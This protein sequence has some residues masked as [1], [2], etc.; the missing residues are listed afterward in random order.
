[1]LTNQK[2]KKIL[3]VATIP[4][5]LRGFLLPF[6]RHFRE[7]GWCVDG[8]ACGISDSV[9]CVQGFDRVWDVKWSRNPLDPRNLMVTPQIIQKIVQQEKY[10]IVHVHTPVAAFVTRYALKDL[11][12]QLNTQVIYT[13]HGFHF[14][15]G[16][17]PLKNAVFLGIEKF[18]ANWND[19]LVVINRDDEQ[20]AKRYRFHPPDKI[21]YMPG[22]GVDVNYYSP[23]AIST[24][25]VERVRQE[26]EI[27]AET[28]LFLSVAELN[29]GKRHGD[30]LKAL[31][32]LNRPHICMAF[33]G[34]GPML[35]NLQQL[36]SALGVENQVRFL[37]YRRDISALMLA[38][39]ATIL[40]SERE[41][42]PRSVMESMCLGIPVIGAKARGTQD[43]LTE[44]CGLLV[45]VG[46]IEALAVSIGW[47][48]DHPQEAHLIGKKGRER[49]A[50]YDIS[51]VL[52]QHKALYN[53]AL[54]A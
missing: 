25:E 4:G 44:G 46:D 33:A 51:Q 11:R 17:K 24:S 52:K 8:M 22:I 49:V 2:M 3:M 14:H 10:D 15:P 38:S 47:I 35:E 50:D 19:H 21:H 42:L 13:A 45:K 27:S 43:L 23:D 26:L 48:L 18:A 12:K 6:A 32:R 7:Q 41:G 9:D 53:Q 1:M 28:P 39:V 20:A 31:A 30:I 29:S 40:A 37:G 36:A 16:G 34:T 54:L 5:T